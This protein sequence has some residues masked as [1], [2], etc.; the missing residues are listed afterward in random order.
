MF[1]K[2]HKKFRKWD[3]KLTAQNKACMLPNLQPKDF[4]EKR[5][6]MLNCRKV[7]TFHCLYRHLILSPVYGHTLN[8]VKFIVPLRVKLIFSDCLT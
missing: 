1:E 5:L 2:V 7:A 8:T 3:K 4:I 6:K